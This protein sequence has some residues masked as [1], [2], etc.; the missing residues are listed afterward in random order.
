MRKTIDFWLFSLIS[1]LSLTLVACDKIYTNES[2]IDDDTVVDPVKS[3]EFI[4]YSGHSVIG[5]TLG[6]RAANVNGNLWYQNW[7][8]PTNVNEI[9]AN[10]TELVKNY[11]S[12]KRE[13]VQNEYK[14]TWLNFWVQQVYKGQTSYTDG[15]NQNIGLGSNHMDHLQVFNNL[16]EE[17]ISWWPYQSN[18]VEWEGQY[19]HINNF[20]SGDNQTIYTDDENGKQYIGTTLMTTMG[21]DG[22][23]EQFAYHNSTDS[24]Y[25]FEYIIIPGSEIDPS[26]D[27]FYY[28]GF[29]FYAHGTDVYPANKNMDVERDWVFDDWIIRISPAN[30]KNGTA[31]NPVL[32]KIVDAPEVDP[33][34]V[35]AYGGE[36]EVNL[37]VNDKKDV[38]DYIA[39]KLGIHVRDTTDVEVYIPVDA[40]YYCDADDMNIVLSHRLE[41]EQHSPKAE[42]IVYEVNGNKVRATVTFELGGIRIKTYG[43][44]ADVLK[45]LREQYSDG[46]TFEIWNYYNNSITREALKPMLDNTTISFTTDPGRYV[47]AFAK[48]NNI[49]NAWD[50][51]VTPPSEFKVDK[52]N[53]GTYNYNV[54]YMK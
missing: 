42:E 27:G 5:S 41:I 16:K 10:E 18:I 14:V 52:V 15:Y 44:N 34:V 29:D 22:R 39:T 8:R 35:P 49:K 54:I 24:K 51:V 38:D 50:C 20:N 31:E 53:D 33:V 28:I 21:T 40:Q 48:L 45:Y 47:N 2:S 12:T 32:P 37:S 11:F 7:E 46:I 43:I 13:N 19:E 17:V 26:L 25:H 9:V 23:N 6:T 30:V 3:S 4:V 1:V 36:V